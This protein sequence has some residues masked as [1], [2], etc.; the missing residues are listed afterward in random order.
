MSKYAKTHLKKNVFYLPLK[1]YYYSS[2]K[3]DT[4]FKEST[5]VSMIKNKKDTDISTKGNI[6]REDL[7]LAEVTSPI[8]I[9]LSE[10]Q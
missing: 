8:G 6:M 7:Q 2:P 1:N 5:R 10:A 9:Q 3:S 4:I